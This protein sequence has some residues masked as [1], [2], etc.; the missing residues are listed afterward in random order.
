MKTCKENGF[1]EREWG[2]ERAARGKKKTKN[3]R[4][5]TAY[6]KKIVLERLAYAE[7]LQMDEEMKI[8]RDKL[9]MD[10]EM[11]EIV[12]MKK[13]VEIKKKLE[14]RTIVKMKNREN[15]KSWKKNREN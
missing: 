9:K 15:D 8:S 6:G 12:E 13:I 14:N 10:L 2:N 4:I 3:A 1:H 7:T 5:K 11:N